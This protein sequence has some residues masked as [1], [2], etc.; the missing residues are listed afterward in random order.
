MA[1]SAVRATERISGGGAAP[2]LVSSGTLTAT[3]RLGA[4]VGD[5]MSVKI[6]FLAATNLAVPIR[7]HQFVDPVSVE[8]T[9]PIERRGHSQLGGEQQFDISET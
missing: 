2:G 1:S 7:L 3:I 5:G 6:T 4:A 8:D 9:T